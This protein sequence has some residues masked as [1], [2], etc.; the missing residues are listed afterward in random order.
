[1]RLILIWL[2]LILISPTAL[3][4]EEKPVVQV[5]FLNFAG[6]SELSESGEVV[7]KGVDL[8]KLLFAEAGYPLETSILPAARIWSGLEDGSIH[9]WP[10]IF[11]KPD[12]E[13][14]TLQN[15]RDLG[16]VAIHLYYLPGT[17][18]PRWPE[19]MVDKRVITITNFTYTMGL[20][21]VLLNPQRNLTIHKSGSHLGA[22]QMLQRG[23]GD[24]LLDYPT[25]VGAALSTL[26]I[27]PLP[28]VQIA[29]VPMRFIFSRHS[30]FAERLRDDLDL[31]YDRLQARGVVLDVSLM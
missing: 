11:N 6:Y 5:T 21:D 25:Q 26:G 15:E 4:T 20:Q 18:P 2:A 16:W 30:G 9:V 19:D 1:M 24:Y 27:E 3:A 28:S 12:L 23:R 31:A 8:V 17:P 22:M 13:Q 14:H 29:R 7:G 10:G